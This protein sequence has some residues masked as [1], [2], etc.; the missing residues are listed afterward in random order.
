MSMLR[1]E[2][3]E[4]T[5]F[6]ALVTDMTRHKQAEQLLQV[7]EAFVRDILDS[8]SAHICVLNQEG[9]IIQTNEAWKRFAQ[10]NSDQTATIGAVGD[11]YLEVCRRAIVS[12]DTTVRPILSGI[13]AV[14]AETQLV[15][16]TEYTCHSPKK[17][18]WFLLRVTRLR[19]ASGVVLSHTDI[20]ERQQ[21]EASLHAKQ[22]ELEQSRA[23][24]RDLTTKLITAQE[25]ER[26][27][28]ARDLHDDITQRLAA[29]TID[30]GNLR[31]RESDSNESTPEDLE[32]LR[33]R[34][35]QLTT[36]VQRLSHELHPTI[37]DHL[38]LEEAV[39]EHVEEFA[40]RT[41]LTTQVVTRRLPTTIPL[42]HA[43]CLY[44]V[45][46][47]SLQNIRKHANATSVL[48]R[49]LKTPQGVGLCVHDDGRGFEQAQETRKLRGMGLSSMA[50]RVGILK[51][52]FRVRTKPGDGTEIYASIPLESREAEGTG[53]R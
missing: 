53:V 15:F 35:K 23:Q 48:V 32:Q 30:L 19:E 6:L 14:L 33:K 42:Q 22:V 37:L 47:E 5:Y 39:R 16:S 27:R 43:T 11:N 10:A 40:A 26:R 2:Q 3:G 7:S 21:A 8:L 24:L 34:A 31:V 29:L 52:T 38:G 18:R 25:E 9:G 36:D 50:E 20:T 12:G 1:S 4:P 49:L 28:L 41:G 45:L 46:Q 13:E 44:R 17:E 51:G